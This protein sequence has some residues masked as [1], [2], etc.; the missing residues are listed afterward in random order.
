LF[1]EYKSI[2]VKQDN[3]SFNFVATKNH[4]IMKNQNLIFYI[5]I[6]LFF[7]TIF[8]CS[9]QP[10]QIII[11]KNN[12]NQI[13]SIDKALRIFKNEKQIKNKII[14]PTLREV[15][16][17][18]SFEDTEF[19]WFSLSEMKNYI[20]YI[21]TVQKENPKNKISGVRVYMG[22][23]DRET[24]EKYAN[25]QTVFFVPTVANKTINSSFENLNHLPFGILPDNANNPLKGQFKVIEPLVYDTEDKKKRIHA[26]E[27]SNAVVDE[28]GFG[29]APIFRN[30]IEL[31]SLVLNEG[32]L[33]PPPKKKD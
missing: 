4:T 3:N 23:Y 29:F 24:S 19:A 22:R 18:D 7:I 2:I 9:E 27:K 10:S 8:S 31:T 16:K 5:P 25:Q 32:E 15:Y 13:I 21:E 1:F 11:K 20:N 28:A 26:F 6:L 12:P 17:D 14:N 30:E 33:A